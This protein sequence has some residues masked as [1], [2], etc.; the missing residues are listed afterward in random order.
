MF[1]K[2]SRAISFAKRFRIISLLCNSWKCSA[3]MLN[4][5]FGPE[6]SVRTVGVLGINLDNLVLTMNATKDSLKAAPAWRW[7]DT[8]KK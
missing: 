2:Q 3:S 7:E 6:Q 5:E 1:R 8:T 4:G